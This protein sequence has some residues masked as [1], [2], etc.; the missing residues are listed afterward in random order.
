MA[1]MITD[2]CIACGACEGE[3]PNDAISEGERIFEIDPAKCTECVG[4]FEASQCESVC[5]VDACVPDPDRRE[6]NEELLEKW[7]R[8]HPDKEPVSGTY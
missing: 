6:S 8:L 7:R 1:Y 5:P 4:A 2:D 3:C